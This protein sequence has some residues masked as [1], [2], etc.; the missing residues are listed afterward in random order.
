MFVVDRNA[1]ISEVYAKYTLSYGYD[2]TEYPNYSD[3]GKSTTDTGTIAY[4]QDTKFGLLTNDEKADDGKAA[5]DKATYKVSGNK[6][7]I[8]LNYPEYNSIAG[9][10]YIPSLSE[11]S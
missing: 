11:N 9:Y 2:S 1:T 5:W 6:V 10:K 3:Y 7:K 8:S 4:N